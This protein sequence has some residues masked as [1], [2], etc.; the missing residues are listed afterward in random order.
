[1]RVGTD[2]LKK[3]RTDRFEAYN[4]M[5]G[6]NCCRQVCSLYKCKNARAAALAVNKTRSEA[7]GCS[8]FH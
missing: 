2:K 8:L 5:L 4:I 3:D 1:M 6:G 7:A